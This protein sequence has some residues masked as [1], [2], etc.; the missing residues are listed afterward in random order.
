M[1]PRPRKVS[2]EQVFG[3][4]YRVMQRA[5]PGE[6]TLAEIAREAGVTASALVQRYGSK[7]ALMLRLFEGAAEGTEALFASL[8]KGRRSPLAVVRAYADCMASM[9][10]TPAGLAHH[11]SY[12]Q[13]DF[14]DPEFHEHSRAQARASRDGIRTLLDEAVAVGE[15]KSKT[16]TKSLARLVE[17]VIGGSLLSWGFHQEGPAQSW[18]RQDL[19]VAL[20][21]YVRRGRP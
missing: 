6:L 12:L 2:D 9:A 16:D 10:S 1:S 19:R 14:T 17:A 18:M 3:A 15:L 11:L 8:R 13:L 20:R 4:A 21:P 5:G 7:R